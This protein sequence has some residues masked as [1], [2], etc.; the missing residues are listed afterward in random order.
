M[1]I[2]LISHT[3]TIGAAPGETVY[4]RIELINDGS[5]DST[6]V[7]VVVGLAT[8]P[9]DEIP[10]NEPTSVFVPAGS[11]VLA[12]IAIRIPRSLGIGQHAAAFEAGSDRPD[13]RAVLTP[14]TISIASV[15]RVEMT[16][17]P[18][19]IRARRRADFHLDIVN[20]EPQQVQVEL[21]GEAPD[22]EVAFTPSAL[23]LQP[24]QRAVSKG[25]V[26]GP[27]NLAGEPI[28]HNILVT[29]RGRASTTSVTAPYI[30]RPLFAHRLRSVVA[31][32]TVVALWL[33]AIL[34]AGIWLANR[35]DGSSDTI[36]LIGKDIDGDGT[37]DVFVLSDGTSVTGTDTDGDGIP[38][39]FVDA[40]GNVI[41]GLDTDGDGIPD[42]IVDVDG[43]EID[44]VDTNGDGIPDTLSDGSTDLSGSGDVTANP[45]ATTTILRGTVA[46]DGDPNDVLVTLT[47]IELGALPADPPQP[48]A[49][50]GAVT[51]APSGKIW[52]ARTASLADLAPTVRRTTAIVSSPITPDAN[53]AFVLTDVARG[54]TYEVAFQQPGFDTQAFV[55][56]PPP[57]GDVLE[58][59]VEMVP[60]KGSL[61]GRVVGPSGGLSGAE[62]T[63]SDGTLVFETTS[64]EGGAW[65][66]DAVSTPGVYT[67]TAALRG[68]GTAVRQVELDAGDQPSSI[69]LQMLPGL[70][71]ITGRVTD[72]NGVGLGGVTVT[73]SNGDT[74]LTTSTLTD[75]NKGFFSLPQLAIPSTY[76]VDVTLD[77]YVT[78]SRRVQL[79]GSVGDLT[80][81]MTATT[82]RLTGE[83]LSSAGGPIQSAGLKIRTSTTTGDLEF[84]ATTS[85]SGTF[86]VDRLP[87]GNYTVLVE[88]FEH[89]SATQFVTLQ[90]GAPPAPLRVTLERTDGPPVLGTGSLVV[91]VVNDDPTIDPP[92]I[93]GATVTI[94]RNRT[95]DAPRAIRDAASPNVIFS[96]LP[97]GTYTVRVIAPG[98]NASPPETVTVGFAQER[99]EVELQ[100]LGQAR[101]SLIDS[102]TDEVLTD[103]AVTIF[104]VRS[105]GLETRIGRF[106][107]TDGEW[108]T[109]PD[110]LS[111]GTYRVVF[112]PGDAPPGYVVRGDQFLD[113]PAAVAGRPMTF[114]VPVVD[115]TVVE[116]I[117]VPPIE[118]DLY[119]AIS[120]RVYEPRLNGL[121][122]EFD[123]I[124]DP[125]LS[126]TGECNG[127][128][129]DPADIVKSD[130]AGIR[131]P[132]QLDEFSVDREV[133][134][135]VVPAADLPGT[136]SFVVSAPGYT[137]QPIEF[138]NVDANNGVTL[139]NRRAAVPVAKPA[140][141]VSGNV[142]WLDNGNGDK[143][144]PLP[145]VAIQ[146]TTPV[147]TG[148][149]PAESTATIAEPQP[150]IRRAVISTTSSTATATKG[151]WTLT[152]TATGDKQL[153]GV[154]SF[155]FVAPNFG[156]TLGT[157]LVPITIDQTATATVPSSP[158]N[159][160][161][162]TPRAGG[163]FNVELE[164]PNPGSV[165]GTVK[166]FTNR[167]PPVYP[168][169]RPTTTPNPGPAAVT[170]TP[171]PGRLPDG[172][173]VGTFSFPIAEAGTW[174]ISWTTP[175]N[176]ALV[177]TAKSSE[178]KQ[179]L[180]GTATPGFDTTYVELGAV[181]VRFFDKANPTTQITPDARID[182][183][184]FATA[185]L[186]TTTPPAAGGP[187]APGDT[188]RIDR[189]PVDASNPVG[190][191]ASYTMKITVP[192]FDTVSATVDT[193]PAVGLQPG[194]STTGADA[195][196]VK[197]RAGQ[198]KTYDV[199]LQRFGGL[200]GSIQGE[201]EGG[202]FTP[203]LFTDSDPAFP[204]GLNLSAVP[205]DPATGVA[206]GPPVTVG[207]GPNGTFSFTGPPGFYR[208]T[209]MHPEYQLATA[210]NGAIPASEFTP[211]S[212]F[213]NVFE[214][215]N[216]DTN[217]LGPYRLKLVTGTI[218]VSAVTD[219]A[220]GT[221]QPGA[222]FTVTPGS[223]ICSATTPG[224][225]ITVN[226]TTAVPAL[227]P[228]PY[229]V[230]VNKFVSD[231]A[232]GFVNDAFPAIVIVNVPRQI[233]DATPVTPTVIA[234]LP[235]EQ[236]TVTGALVAFNG[237]PPG[238][239]PVE[240]VAPAGSVKVTSTYT[241]TVSVTGT[242][243][244]NLNN[245][246][247]FSA[248]A[249]PTVPADFSWTYTFNDLPYGEHTITAPDI[250]GYDLIGPATVKIPVNVAGPSP[251]PE[252]R[253]QVAARDVAFQLSPGDYPS[254]DSAYPDTTTVCLKVVG[255][256]ACVGG[257]ASFAPATD[258]LTINGVPPD[259]RG[260]TLSFDDAL[261][262][263]VVDRPVT[264]PF[265]PSTATPL[266]ALDG[267][268]VT[269]T[270]DRV[271]LTGLATQLAV[272]GSPSALQT[273][274]DLTLSGPGGNYLLEPGVTPDPGTSLVDRIYT[275]D[276]AIA[277]GYT[278]ELTQN[279]YFTTSVTPLD[280]AASAGTVVTQNI[281]VE[282]KAI[283]TIRT[284]SGGLALPPGTAYSLLNS[285]PAG[286]A[287]VATADPT[288]YEVR[289]GT[290]VAQVSASGGYPTQ[291]SSAT[292]VQLG[293]D[294]DITVVLPR[295]ARVD[296][297]GPPAG[298]LA[299]VAIGS[300]SPVPPQAVPS[301]FVFQSPAIPTS[302]ALTARVT[303]SEYRT[304]VVDVL[305][306]TQL[307][308]TTPVPVVLKPDA[309]ATGTI[310]GAPAG[311]G[312]ISASDGTT[313]KPG[314]I[315]LVAGTPRYTIPGLGVGPNGEPTTWSITYNVPG[316]GFTGTLGAPG[317]AGTVVPVALPTVTV[318]SINEIPLNITLAVRPVLYNFTVTDNAGTPNDLD[319][320]T[321]KILTA[322]DTVLATSGPTVDGKVSLSVLENSKPAKWTVEKDGYL[323][324]NGTIGSVTAFD[325]N[326]G[327][328][329]LA[330]PTFSGRIVTG[331]ADTP[332]AA[333][334]VIICP[335]SFSAAPCTGADIVATT[336][337]TVADGVFTFTEVLPAPSYR[338]W[339]TT[340][341]SQGSS[342]LTVDGV[343][344]VLTTPDISIAP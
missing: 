77:G 242:T 229:C 138:A 4:G 3:P 236:P 104:Q 268:T 336:G 118:A 200:T 143:V 105:S 270:A 58:L 170:P 286:F 99:V 166:I 234:P 224:Q 96:D 108:Q 113:D 1:S 261:H 64:T 95:T 312:V 288:K 292:T 72:E 314:N 321:V 133:I 258:V 54:Q 253:Y 273:G 63:V 55:V 169:A 69:D 83:V 192:G 318:D 339:A 247:T 315:E 84:R 240:I 328:V 7:V 139:S 219:L 11:S 129:L 280:L 267:G 308:N 216:A 245:P 80:F 8:D 29:A 130:Q 18:S 279:G 150:G 255:T 332:V 330:P 301:I 281:Q 20:N 9:T 335:A 141:T 156:A 327:P 182:L 162:V 36:E 181:E 225:S 262:A 324:G 211:P 167:V 47:A 215:K 174:T 213:E 93:T 160:A 121:N 59:D 10:P 100:R 87:P 111:T 163:G 269:T 290:Y 249:A 132:D 246:G 28:Q 82:V 67:V 142:F 147:I 196:D 331:A 90:A 41:L 151:D 212:P 2:R 32:I 176:H 158:P 159:A 210:A 244:P 265:V 175:P 300:G 233:R 195:I 60:S 317:T 19:T 61:G 299:S 154:S 338:V 21:T 74:T 13:E 114:L 131:G 323:T 186:P 125:G 109:P 140:P 257:T 222:S 272:V 209:P 298:T 34:G 252:F 91:A 266:P 344:A 155:Q 334:T 306:A 340:T 243:V 329:E 276:A 197:M 307:F 22:V 237:P 188:Y 343:G 217:D 62:I 274:A 152:D 313:P 184:G 71:T 285:N 57:E 124:D 39:R 146:S 185:S 205:V 51:E 183:S 112:E 65:F 117:V 226:P 294:R 177:G 49:F 56:T 172:G 44:A 304:Q 218:A 81:S 135:R 223:A 101:G 148:F 221:F 42:A 207:T 110:A 5:T 341:T 214:V 68:F 97:I 239:G 220:S 232:G 194:S 23:L 231:G 165:S 127:T 98:Y 164:P 282:K 278:L 201:L 76:A 275:I 189:L 326:V 171:T 120:A 106:V 311:T 24:G 254:L 264:V 145:G 337:P 295:I 12:D 78:Q 316:V 116:P 296:V 128:A 122:V 33:A 284:N 260:Y 16:P 30:Q 26:K 204:G 43:D 75:G 73:A 168:D 40:D 178:T 180:P 202:S 137:P 70:G 259:A 25:R 271:R 277:D 161:V 319:G 228:G 27:R 31:G 310:L 38:D 17:Q 107:E 325:V 50:R 208:L 230:S 45:A 190:A 322:D 173:Q 203:L 303:A 79:G 283:V 263:S 144:E 85:E 37:I 103:Y 227:R 53:G 199:F 149:V 305:S 48:T 157:G 289:P 179:V 153:F 126:V 238:G 15:A 102:L 187:N 193:D 206:S 302:G 342:T 115:A 94:T 119:P 320:A 136:C 235:L 333:A 191:D 291:S 241:N 309:T 89:Q 256:S 134:A 293:T 250:P 35:D 123:P 297:S 66:L 248:T 92:G 52:S 6:C 86:E 198:V 88:H 287:P 14:F 251:G 46:T